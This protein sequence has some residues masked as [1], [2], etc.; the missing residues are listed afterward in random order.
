MN[1]SELQAEIERLYDS[2]Q[3][4][5]QEK[6]RLIFEEFISL[7]DQGEIRAA[8]L[9]G[10]RWVVHPWVK[11]GILLGFRIG[12]I[13]DYSLRPYWRFFDKDTYPLKEFDGRADL[14]RIVPGGSSVRRGAFLGP[15]VVIMPPS[16]INVGAYVGEATMVDSHVLIGSCAQIGQRVHLSAGT[17]IGGVLEPA[18][19]LPVIIEDDVFV[20]GHCGLFEGVIVRRRAVLSAGVILTG[21]TPVYDLVRETVYRRSETEPLIIPE[22]AVVVPGAR[23][24]EGEFARA[25]Q[26]LIAA[27]LIV[28]YRDERTDARTALE[29]SLR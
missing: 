10:D 3:K 27:P 26:L 11:K 20:G 18:G 8:E 25:R 7:L 15:H 16:Y 17:Q 29:M 13:R 6:A 9:V 12:Q 14:I 23:P 21:S 1:I 5:D 22:G 4:G 19:A 28:K 24:A 2:S